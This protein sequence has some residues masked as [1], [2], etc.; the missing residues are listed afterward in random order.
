[1]NTCATCHNSYQA[2]SLAI[3]CSVHGCTCTET[4]AKDCTDYVRATGSDDESPAHKVWYCDKPGR[5]D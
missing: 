4:T 2:P 5:G 3:V 1:M